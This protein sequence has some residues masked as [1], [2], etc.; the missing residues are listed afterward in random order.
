MSLLIKQI[1]V[2]PSM[3]KDYLSKNKVNRSLS[4]E[5]VNTYANDMKN[6]NWKLNGETFSV[7]EFGNLC[8]GQHRMNA[9]IKSNCNIEMIAAIGVGADSMPTFD[10]GKPRNAG[11]VF[12]INEILNATTV[13][14]GVSKY[15]RLK[16]GSYGTQGGKDRY[17]LTNTDIL[18][19]YNKHPDLYQSLF[20]RG[21]KFY[22]SNHKIISKSDFMAY[23]KY[24]MAKYTQEK[25]DLFFDKIQSRVGVCGMLF[26]K[27]MNDVT[28]KRKMSSS[29]KSAIIIKSFNIYSQNRTVKILK[30]SIDE[31]FPILE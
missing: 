16:S 25:I 17:L 24:F 31:Q 14:A 15:M 26:N 30:I 19:E 7:D 1:V 6:G 18:E 12:R 20:L 4:Q 8:N 3:A 28:A 29:E 21:S 11:D 23:Y 9:I 10:T 13:A 27:L 5:K 22:I 2:T